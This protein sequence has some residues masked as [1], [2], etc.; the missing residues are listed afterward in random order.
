MT[1]AESVR[2][3][4]PRWSAVEQAMA[5]SVF[6]LS[7]RISAFL[8]Y[9]CLKVIEGRTDELTEQQIGIHVFQRPA[10][11]NPGEDNIVRSAARQLRQKLTVF[12]DSS[13]EASAFRI[14]VPKGGYVPVFEP[15][16]APEHSEAEPA[17]LTEARHERKFGFRAVAAACLGACA[18][19]LAVTGIPAL[20]K[21][22]GL[23]NEFW[24]Q[25][26]A[27]DKQTLIVVGDAELNLLDNLARRQV[28]L[29][30]Y[31]SGA[32]LSISQAQTPEGYDW[33]PLAH[34]RYTTLA[35]LELVEQLHRLPQYQ[36]QMVSVRFARDIRMGEFKGRNLVLAGSPVTNPWSELVTGRLNFWITYDGVANSVTVHNRRPLAGEQESY[37]WTEHDSRHRGY[38]HIALTRNPDGSGRL[39]L[40]EGTTM[41]GLGAAT[42]FVTNASK[43]K[44]RAEPRGPVQTRSGDSLGGG[45]GGWQQPFGEGN[46]SAV[47]LAPET[48]GPA[49][50]CA[51]RSLNCEPILWVT[52]P[53]FGES[54]GR[55]FYFTTSERR[56]R[57]L[58]SRGCIG[59][60]IA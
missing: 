4:D 59:A 41:A 17:S 9:I 55:F 18:V 2:Q 25:I 56:N 5:S 8:S 57:I 43:L 19:T 26:F 21:T 60:E 33:V 30:D 15:S 22:S 53:D 54:R 51:T 44:G 35:D 16:A 14:V 58:H 24:R 7:P 10:D 11:Y 37:I 29:R 20:W 52:F 12:Y 47:S 6:S 28:G 31:L 46:C 39:L 32:Y 40:L 3:P 45:N 1:E 36:S 27:A 49:A 38:A 13:E 34:R 48:Y 23:N 42:D 50:D